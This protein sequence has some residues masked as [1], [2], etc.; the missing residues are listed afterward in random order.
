MVGAVPPS[1]AERIVIATA[2]SIEETNAHHRAVFGEDAIVAP[3]GPRGLAAELAWL[4]AAEVTLD[5][6]IVGSRFPGSAV[7]RR[8]AALAWARETLDAL[9][10]GV[11]AELLDGRPA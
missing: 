11:S 4:D 8:A 1:T 6:L 3:W 7:D 2:V 9:W 10:P 5:C